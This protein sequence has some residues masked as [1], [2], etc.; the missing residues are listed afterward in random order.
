MIDLTAE[1]LG[2]EKISE[3]PKKRFGD[4]VYIF[5]CK[6]FYKIGRCFSVP[7]RLSMMQV[8][9]P[10]PIEEIYSRKVQNPVLLEK[11]LH[12]LF[13]NKHHRGEWFILDDYDLQEAVNVIYHG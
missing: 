11:K 5:R 7:N 12:K 6:E 9:C 13:S 4:F 1:L 8:G 2:I 10:F 3:L